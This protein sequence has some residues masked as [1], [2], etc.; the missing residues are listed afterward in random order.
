MKPYWL[1]LALLVAGCGEEA[2]RRSS[3]NPS[4]ASADLAAPAQVSKAPAVIPLPKDQAQLDRLILA[5]YTPHAS[6]LH[7]PGVE[8]CPI[9]EGTDAVM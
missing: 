6:H 4:P 1:L 8:R 2:E 5:G 7:A 3:A 9:A